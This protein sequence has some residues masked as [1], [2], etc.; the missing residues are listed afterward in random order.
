M[1]TF[2]MFKRINDIIEDIIRINNRIDII[3]RLH[4]SRYKEIDK[5]TSE[6]LT[7]KNINIHP[8]KCPVCDGK[9]GFKNETIKIGERLNYLQWQ[10]ING[11]FDKCTACEGRGI[12]W[13]Q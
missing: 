10:D 5:M 11:V 2:D 7:S 3:E 1:E 8:Y 4:C 13:G 6:L 12:F 9:C